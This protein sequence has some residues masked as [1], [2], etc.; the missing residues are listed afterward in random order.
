MGLFNALNT[1]ITGLGSNGLALSV[2]GDN[3]SHLN[4]NGFKGSTAQFQDLI[5]QKLDGGKGTLGLGSATKNLYRN[6]KDLYRA[7]KDLYIAKKCPMGLRDFRNEKKRPHTEK[8]F[9]RQASPS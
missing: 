9:G 3:I 7:T 6:T 4:T 8:Y 1:G 5:V 2:I